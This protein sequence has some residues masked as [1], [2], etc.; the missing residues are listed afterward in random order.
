M[1][2]DACDPIPEL[3]SARLDGELGGDEL[4]LLDEHLA[5]CAECRALADRLERADRHVRVRPAHPVPDLREAV[6]ARVQPA[7]L[8][9]GGWLRPALAW[10]SVVICV[11]SV[12]ALVSGEVSGADTH[13]A[14]HLGAFG[15]ALAVGFAYVVWRPHRAVGMLP[16]TSALLAAMLVSA[17]IDVIDGGS[18]VLAEAVHLG[19]LIGLALVWMI[20]GSPGLPHRRPRRIHSSPAA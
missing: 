5:G 20:A 7:R 12:I 4:V 1:R 10:V 14:R 16:F 18:S 19:E 6:L 3:L 9:R 11:Q 13:Q 15:L 8:G 17:V 2:P